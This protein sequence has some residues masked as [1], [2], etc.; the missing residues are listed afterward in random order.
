M[1]FSESRRRILSLVVAKIARRELENGRPVELNRPLSRSSSMAFDDLH[2]WKTDRPKWRGIQT[3]KWERLRKFFP[4]KRRSYFRAKRRGRP[5][6]P[7][8]ITFEALLWYMKTTATWKALPRYRYCSPR[9]LF[10][11]LD[12]W[13]RDG[14]LVL[15][16]KAYLRLLDDVELAYWRRAFERNELRRRAPWMEPLEYYLFEIGFERAQFVAKSRSPASPRPGTM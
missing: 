8:Q 15:A 12:C 7:D 13:R 14:R 2:V 4:A 6:I 1:R 5:R 10:R 3:F 16:W 9:T 11:R